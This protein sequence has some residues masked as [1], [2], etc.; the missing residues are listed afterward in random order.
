MCGQLTFF[1]AFPSYPVCINMEPIL[2]EW[3]H[4]L[5]EAPL[6]ELWY[7]ALLVCCWVQLWTGCSISESISLPSGWEW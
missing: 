7:T 3:A 4:L 1:K 5:W 2:A 6:H